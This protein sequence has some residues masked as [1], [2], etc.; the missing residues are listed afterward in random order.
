MAAFE[1]IERSTVKAYSLDFE[2]Q[3]LI[4]YCDSNIDSM[5]PCV[6]EAYGKMFGS[7]Y[8]NVVDLKMALSTTAGKGK[9]ALTKLTGCKQPCKSTKYDLVPF[10][11][12]KLEHHRDPGQN[13]L[14]DS[15]SSSLLY[16]THTPDRTIK[17]TEERPKYTIISFISDVGG[18]CGVFLGISFWSI[19]NILIFPMLNKLQ[20]TIME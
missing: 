18:I 14:L 8:N 1:S 19:Y 3:K 9:D 10:A 15:N 7:D 2:L 16:I 11:N 6:L 13:H 20:K 5:T 4:S 17:M 12:W